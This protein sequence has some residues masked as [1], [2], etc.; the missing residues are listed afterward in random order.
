MARASTWM[1]PFFTVLPSTRCR[2]SAGSRG[3]T[4]TRSRSTAS[5]WAS[6]KSGFAAQRPGS[7]GGLIAQPPAL[8]LPV[9][10]LRQLGDKLNESRVLVGRHFPF[11]ELLQRLHHAAVGRETIP[12]D[13]VGHHHLTPDLIRGG[14]HR[15]VRNRLML[16][17]DQLDLGCG[18]LGSGRH[19]HVVQAALEPQISFQVPVIRVIAD[20]PAVD[21]VDFGALANAWVEVC[22]VG[23][24]G[25]PANGG[26]P[27][28]AGWHRRSIFS[29][30]S[31]V[32][33]R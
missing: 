27:D 30:Q 6:R 9:L 20:A 18:N 16:L 4:R 3:P 24:A 33:P 17:E 32:V 25:R 13:D 15:D 22:P 7:A 10:V 28:V 14:D 2:T 21:H 23:D 8:D 31:N 26:A 29:D 19:D 5:S 1:A 11:G 12:E